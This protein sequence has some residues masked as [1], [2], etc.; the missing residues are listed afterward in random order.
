MKTHGVEISISLHLGSGPPCTWK[1]EYVVIKSLWAAA[2][3]QELQSLPKIK[4]VFVSWNLCVVE[5]SVLPS[6]GQET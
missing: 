1:A 5:N 2:F 6:Y 4:I 3:F